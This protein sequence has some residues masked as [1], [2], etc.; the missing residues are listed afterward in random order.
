MIKRILEISR[1]PSHLAVRDA[2]LLILRKQDQPR[3]LPAHPPNLA[4]SVPLED[5]GVVVVDEDSTTYSHRALSEIAA[6]GAAVIICGRDHLPVGVLLPIS[7]HTEVVWRQDDQISVGLPVKKRLWQRIIRAK[8]RAQSAALIPDESGRAARLALD[9][10]ASDVTSGDSEN[11]EAQAA[12]VYWGVWLGDAAA[13][14]Q[15]R[16]RRDATPGVHAAA[17]NCFL[18]YGYALIRAATARALVGAGLL[19]SLGIKHR[20]RSN[21]FCLADDLMEPLRPLVD[22]VARDL[23]LAGER[24][25]S[26]QNKARLLLL[27]TASTQSDGPSGVEHR[28]GPLMVA[29]HLYAA[30]FAKALAVRDAAVLSIPVPVPDH[31]PPLR[32]PPDPESDP[33]L[34]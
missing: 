21:A 4:G 8:I 28:T 17:P 31:R 30:S 9:R 29:L 11:C 3:S 23:F 26:Q 7:E 15:A 5:V 16:F 19:P 13:E 1:E 33:E 18:N 12:R 22:T 10:I 27:L 2:Q 25:L 6:H 32:C 34:D 24:H 20:H 14:S